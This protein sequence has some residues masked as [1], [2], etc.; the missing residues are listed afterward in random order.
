MAEEK[1]G[2]NELSASDNAL[3]GSSSSSEEEN[4]N[5]SAP[6]PSVASIFDA[7]GV[8]VQSQ[9]VS[10]TTIANPDSFTSILLTVGND[11]GKEDSNYKGTTS[12]FILK[13][14]M[15]EFKEHMKRRLDRLSTSTM[16]RICII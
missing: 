5:L 16:V 2:R 14:L 6:S 7:A 13:T 15:T 4:P 3:T 1:R 9:P 12:L 11:E 8:A 10:G